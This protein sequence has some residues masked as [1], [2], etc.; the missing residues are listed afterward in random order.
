MTENTRLSLNVTMKEMQRAI[1]QSTLD[2]IVISSVE[3][4]L[5]K[6][7]ITVKP[8]SPSYG[9]LLEYHPSIHGMKEARNAEIIDR[10]SQYIMHRF[11]RYKHKNNN[12]TNKIINVNSIFLYMIFSIFYSNRKNIKT[13]AK[14]LATMKFN[15]TSQGK[16]C[17]SEYYNDTL[18]NGLNLKYRTADGSCNNKNHIFWGRSNTAY[19]RLL[20]PDYTD[21]NI[22]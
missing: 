22:L 10:A 5:V 11:I 15:Q 4:Y 1:N 20:F 9:Q 13:S 6:S 19:K 16:I 17:L 2:I 12:F 18:C 8:N 7:N 3:K 14:I 21:S